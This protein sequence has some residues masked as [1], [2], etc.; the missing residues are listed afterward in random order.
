MSSLALRTDFSAILTV[1]EWA[2]LEEDADGELVDGQLVAAEEG[3]WMHDETTAWLVA[4]LWSWLRAAGGRVATSDVRYR[5]AADRGR[6]PDLSVF[7][8]GTPMPSRSSSLLRSPPT[9]AVEVL[10]PRPSDIRRDRI[11]KMQEYAQFGVTWYWL[12]D[13]NVRLIEIY[14]LRTDGTS[15]RVLGAAQ[16]RISV[17][18]CDGLELDLDDLWAT[19]DGPDEDR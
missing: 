4:A 11:E 8:P 7:L 2:A 14:R 9:I 3:T 5:I 6:K 15:V 18:G 13:P 17:P 10:S 1:E 12:V 19:V 16:G